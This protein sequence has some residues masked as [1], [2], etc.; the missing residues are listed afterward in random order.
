MFESFFEPVFGPHKDESAGQFET[1]FGEKVII[2]LTLCK[3]SKT[4]GIDQGS[5]HHDFVLIER[6]LQILH[7]NILDD[8]RAG[9]VRIAMIPVI[10]IVS[11]EHFRGQDG[12]AGTIDVQAYLV[13]NR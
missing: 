7:N 2:L 3:E 6:F 5:S 4:K 13:K 9:V 11:D 10:Y 12:K 8:A 1:I